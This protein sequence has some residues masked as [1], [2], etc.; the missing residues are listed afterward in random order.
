MDES[1]IHNFQSDEATIEAMETPGFS[2]SKKAK[3]VMS[4]GKVMASI[5]RGVSDDGGLPRQG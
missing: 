4:A 2:V 1:W 5:F 3:T